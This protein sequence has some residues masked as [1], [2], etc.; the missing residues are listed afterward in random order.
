MIA[1]ND[2]LSK[3]NL[4]KLRGLWSTL[5]ATEDG[6]PIPEADV[7]HTEIGIREGSKGPYLQS[8][9]FDENGNPVKE[10]DFTDHGTPNIHPNP[11]QH[12]RKDNPSGG[13]RSREDAEPLTGG[14]INENKRYTNFR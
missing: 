7:S 4:R 3:N 2:L 9:E 14:D 5:P 10:I 12:I 1:Y 6:V 13:T 11:H 8:R